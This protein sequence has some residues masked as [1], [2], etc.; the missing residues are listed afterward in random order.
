[1]TLLDSKQ[2]P[3]GWEAADFTLKDTEGNDVSPSD[4]ADKK[5]L[6]IVFTCNHCPYAKA[7]WPL[8][9]DLSKK[10]SDIAVIAI[11][12]NNA[13]NY[14]D[15]SPRMMKRYKQE[16]GIPFPY[17]FDE[18]QE[19]A[20]KYGARCT[21]D[22]YLFKM[23]DGAFKLYYHG[24]ISDNRSF[25]SAQDKQESIES[26]LEDAMKTLRKNQPPPRHQPPSIGCSI[27][28]K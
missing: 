14:P 24:R 8:I 22:P 25:G 13:K 15:D 3:I 27:K 26:N 2:V 7:A 21:P 9:I 4:F 5:G 11:N 18:T 6:L 28:W 1:M 12:A 10:Y 19:A 20:K 16:W 23:K 17:L